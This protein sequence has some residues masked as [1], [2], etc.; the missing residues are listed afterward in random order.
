VETR[1][2]SGRSA[3]AENV[4]KPR[5]APLA[6]A[7]VLLA[8]STTAGATTR[9]PAVAA[10]PA[11]DR[12]ILTEINAVRAARGLPRLRRSPGLT[13]AATRHSRSMAR[14][15]FFEHESRDGGAF[16]K[17]V[18]RFYGSQGYRTWHVGENLLWASPEI[19]ARRAVQ[20]W[21]NSAGHRRILLDPD[22]H[23]IG[24]AAVHTPSAAGTYEGREITVVTAD[25]GARSHS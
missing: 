10:Q 11:L 25:F 19:D 20:L 4:T 7:L 17:R 12:S 5:F 8:L 24:L 6:C 2:G 14:H 18:R 15:G 23:H 1:N 3:D 22:F 13:A 21:L 16:W 9:R